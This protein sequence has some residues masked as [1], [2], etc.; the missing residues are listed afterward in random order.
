MARDRALDYVEPL[1]A[2]YKATNV[3]AICM[4]RCSHEEVCVKPGE[5]RGHGGQ[6]TSRS[7]RPKA[8]MRRQ[9]MMAT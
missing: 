9:L 1:G 5:T 6:E 8:A 3:L 2:H 4:E 7:S